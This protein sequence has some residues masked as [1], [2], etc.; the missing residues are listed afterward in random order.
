MRP[1]VCSFE[2][3]KADE[4]RSLIER[5]GGEATIAPSMQEVAIGENPDAFEF[6]ELLFQG[7]IDWVIFMT[8]VG[9]RTLLDAVASHYPRDEFLEALSDCFIAV[10]G[11]K[12]F[13]VMREWNI[14]VSLRASEP[15]T[16]K[17]LVSEFDAKTEADGFSLDQKTV[18]VQ[19]YGISN[20]D[21]HAQLRQRGASVIAVPVYR[22][23][24]PDDVG[25][26][27]QSI[28]QTIDGQFDILMFTSANQ[29]TNTLEIADR[30]G[31]REEWIAAAKQCIVASIGPTAS[32]SLKNAGLQVDIQPK[33]PK[34]GH[35]VRETLQAAPDLMRDRPHD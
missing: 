28:R 12:P 5:C 7:K 18:A 10:R 8:G 11:P 21:F 17:E 4:M 26:L 23:E 27:A 29:L 24:L 34:M 13:A 15:N 6:A 2:S 31:L 22:W 35:L 9:A 3:R 1:R 30:E 25:P 16:W 19:E 14:D 20:N 32:E 33:H